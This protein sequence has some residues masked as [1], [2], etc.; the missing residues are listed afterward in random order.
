MPTIRASGLQWRAPTLHTDNETLLTQHR[1]AVQRWRS[2]WTRNPSSD[3]FVTVVD[4][5]VLFRSG[6]HG[7]GSFSGVVYNDSLVVRHKDW[8]IDAPPNTSNSRCD[9]F[10]SGPAVALHSRWLHSFGHVVSD[11]LPM[12]SSVL[13]HSGDAHLILIYTPVVKAIFKALAPALTDRLYLVARDVWTCVSGNLRVL[14]PGAGNPFAWHRTQHVQNFRARLDTWIPF[15]RPRR[16]IVTYT[17]RTRLTAKNGRRIPHSHNHAIQREVRRAMR[18]HQRQEH[19]RVHYGTARVSVQMQLFHSSTF[20]IGPHGASMANTL[21][22]NIGDRRAVPGVLEFICIPL[23]VRVQDNGG[24]PWANT[25]YWFLSGAQWV[26]YHHIGFAP[27][28]SARHTYINLTEL[29]VGLRAL[30]TNSMHL[31]SCRP[32]GRQHS[33]HPFP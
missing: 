32:G 22:M 15:V 20:A 33:L 14:L 31:E 6:S 13:G 23:S 19:F 29:R 2:G 7:Y 1:A 16:G 3:K 28:S 30:F 18:A 11:F 26:D 9:G 21:W 12:V 8:W 24:C 10:V 4:A 17:T 5:R 25:Y 27:N